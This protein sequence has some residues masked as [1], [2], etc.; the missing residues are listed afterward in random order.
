MKDAGRPFDFVVY[1]G[2]GHGFLRSGEQEGARAG[3]RQA[4]TQAWER[5]KKI[6]AGL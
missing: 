3:D 6:L 4:H 2:A 1:D 5:M